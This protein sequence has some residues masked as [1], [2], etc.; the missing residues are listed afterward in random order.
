MTLEKTRDELEKANQK[1]SRSWAK[2]APVYDKSIGFLERHV[3]GPEH[4]AWACS[5]ATGKTLE[6]AIGTGLNLGHYPRDVI[7]TGIDLTP[8]MLAIARERAS[9]LGVDAELKE[10]DAHALQFPDES[11][12]TVI[13]TYT[14]C[15]IPDPRRA[16]AEMKRVL[17]PLG[18]LILVDHIRST[19]KPIYWFQKG[20]E[21]ITSRLE[22]EHMTRRSIEHV[23]A[24]GFE[25]IERERLRA[26]IIERLVAT[27]R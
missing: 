27:K 8:E 22:G 26:G 23:K 6:V 18:K 15:N 2:W 20:L 14:L 16:V 12:D 25:I 19:V 4:R 21:A 9:T 3:F 11:F 7:L 17:R 1:V 13:G 24:E 5:K 10:G